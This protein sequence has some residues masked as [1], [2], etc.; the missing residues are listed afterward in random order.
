MLKSTDNLCSV[1]QGEFRISKSTNDVQVCV[2]GSC[3]AT[4]FYDP[5]TR[6]GGMNHF[7]LPGQDPGAR[8]E[9]KYGAHAMEQLV[10]ALLRAGAARH[11]LQVQ[12]FGGAKVI[13]SGGNIGLNNAQFARQF[14]SEEGFELTKTDV[15]GTCGRRLMYRPATGV[16]EVEILRN[17][18]AVPQATPVRNIPQE[19]GSIELF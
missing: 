13:K 7:L 3:I 8:Q 1:K 12:I 5:I 4:C 11:N 18:A 17:A 19:T 16:A 2:L 9:I 10:N 15:G 14:V 6:L